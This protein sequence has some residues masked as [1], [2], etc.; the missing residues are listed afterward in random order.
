MSS[1][2]SPKPVIP[3][4]EEFHEDK[5]PTHKKTVAKLMVDCLENEGVKLIFGLPGEEN[6][7]FTVA[8]KDSPIN[9]VLVRHEQGA[10]FMADAYG[11]LTGEPGVCFGT[12]GP[13]AANLVTGVADANMDRSPVVVITG[14]ADTHRLHKESHQN[15]DVIGM[16][17]PITK[18][19]TTVYQPDTVNEIVRKAFKVATNEKPGAAH[20]E[21]PEDIAGMNAAGYDPLPRPPKLRRSVP[22]DK[23][24]DQMFQLLKQAK[25]PI[26]L[27]GNGALRHHASKQ[28]EIFCKSTRIPVVSTFMAKGVVPRSEEYCLFTVGLSSGD[29]N[30]ILLEESDFVICIGFDI[31]EYHPRLW[32]PKG[33]LPIAHVDFAPSEVDKHYQPVVEVVGDLSHSLWMLNE[34]LK[35][36]PL[37]FDA[38]QALHIR[39]TMLNDFAEHKGDNTE[40]MIR[41]QKVLWDIREALGPND[42]LLSDVG[43]H[44]MW[45][46][47]YYQCDTPNTCLIPNGFCSM[48][49]ALPG[50]IGAKLAYPDRNIVAVCGDGGFLMNVQ[51]METAKRVGANIIVIVWVDGGYGLIS[52]KQDNRYGFHTNLS[53]NNPDFVK[54]AESFGWEGYHVQ[55]ARDLQ[56]TLKKALNAKS[57]VLISLNVDYSENPKL[58]A[59]LGKLR[60]KQ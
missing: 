55:H 12:L 21:L 30:N 38:S 36:A 58:T 46:A 4:Q 32:N 41:P 20:I 57:P 6:A 2:A 27:A 49:F 1:S 44:K 48:G 51:E 16:F 56:A 47:R 54:L 53:F 29:Y 33:T 39:D 13:G 8:L 43:A 17:K 35:A 25:K 22:D 50:A 24:V 31:V 23:V 42:I 7:D 10:A 40:N 15:M 26:I 45:I 9:F 34:R 3:V 5:A 59:R 11:R 19:N 60:V 14:Q 28:L 18:W 52:W 37:V